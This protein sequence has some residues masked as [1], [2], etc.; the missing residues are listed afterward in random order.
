MNNETYKPIIMNVMDSSLLEL[1]EKGVLDSVPHIYNPD[2][3][4]ARVLHFTPHEKDLELRSFFERFNIEIYA[5]PA[6]GV[7]PIKVLKTLILFWRLL[8]LERINVVR[9]RLP[10]LGS[11]MGG[12]AAKLRGVPFVVSLGGD[13][14][15]V[16][17]RNRQYNYGSRIVSYT[18]EWLV[19]KLAD[20]IIV[21]NNYTKKYVSSIIGAVLADKKC[22]RIPWISNPIPC[23]NILP[24]DNGDKNLIIIV[25]F[26]SRYKYT[27]VIYDALDI[28]V[29]S[30]VVESTNAEILFC[31]DGPLKE[32]GE[33]RFCGVKSI[34]FLGW[35]E[36]KDV[37]RY[38]N[39]A[40]IV[41]VP[42]SGFVLLEAASLGKPVIT[43]DVEWHSEVVH[44]GETGFVVPAS[45]PKAWAEA[46][47]R[48]LSDPEKAESMGAKLKEL[49]MKDYS[50][51]ASIEAEVNLYNQ[52]IAE[53][54][55]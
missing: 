54:S 51:E 33:T 26:L 9:G 30:G 40:S 2:G 46:I 47:K 14:R 36:G 23:E 44:D 41:L 50:P 7:S 42:M 25:G 22:V 13:N 35:T 8:K 12:G 39:R 11:L 16:Q 28:L 34:K 21:P 15:V 19:L 6:Q 43:S 10:Y 1:K 52:L 24:R 29:C 55:K 3:S 48:L 49:Y 20:A 32:A 27:D 4:W 37:H 18:M 5:H 45:D 31:G 53:R 38:L 17:E